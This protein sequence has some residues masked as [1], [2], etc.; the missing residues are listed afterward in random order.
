MAIP[1]FN[2]RGLLP[3][4]THE[5]TVEELR[6]RFGQFIVLDRRGSDRRAKLSEQLLAYL[7]E[8]GATKLVTEVIVNG[9]YVTAK[10]EPNDIDLIVVLAADH[11]FSRELRPFEYNALSKKRVRGHYGFDLFLVRANSAEFEKWL[12][13]FEQVRD[14]P[15]VTKGLLRVRL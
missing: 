6:D 1:P 3:P 14:E 12:A 7:R 5:C 11:D 2:E 10:A 15:D 9:S 4:G 8:V 13:F